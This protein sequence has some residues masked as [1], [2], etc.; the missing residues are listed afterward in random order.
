[1]GTSPAQLQTMRAATATAARPAGQISCHTS[2]SW[3][4]LGKRADPLL[5]FAT[6]QTQT[7]CTTYKEAGGKLRRRMLEGGKIISYHAK[8]GAFKW[9]DV[10][11]T[12]AATVLTLPDLGFLTDDP[13]NSK[14]EEHDV[15]DI[16]NGNGGSST[17]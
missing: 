3:W 9:K 10:C 5:H 17:S 2:S 8:V 7:F 13:T 12:V 4:R 16:T 14:D 11:G 15:H 1:M 6:G